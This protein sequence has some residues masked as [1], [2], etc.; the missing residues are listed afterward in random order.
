M[1]ATT[2]EDLKRYLETI[3]SRNCDDATKIRL[4]EVIRRAVEE[5]PGILEK[6]GITQA[7]L[8]RLP[9]H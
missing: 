6:L 4:A 9:K 2:I 5:Q 1:I 3:R 8:D 7:E